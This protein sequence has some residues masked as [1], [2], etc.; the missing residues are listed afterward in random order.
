[1]HRWIGCS[2]FSVLACATSSATNAPAAASKVPAALEVEGQKPGLEARAV[3][4]QIYECKATRDDP[5]RFDWS[6]V[7]PEATLFDASDKPIGKHYAGPT[8]ESTDGSK[9]V[10][11][12]KARD[13]GPDQGA[14]P[15]LLLDAKSVSGVGVF[16]KTTLIQ[17]LD[18]VGGKAPGQGCTR[19]RA[20][21]QA[22]VDYKA[23]YVFYRSP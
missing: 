11:Q 20:G 22:R 8:W 14:I 19:E 5:S 9:V 16:A 18:T 6:L 1:M 21:D 4:V 10:G 12:V 13:P 7:A 2:L 15:W 17:R 23:R 3:G